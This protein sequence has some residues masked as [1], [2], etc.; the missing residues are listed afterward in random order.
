MP[1]AP[2]QR[3]LQPSRSDYRRYVDTLIAENDRKARDR[4]REAWIKRCVEGTW[5]REAEEAGLSVEDFL[6]PKKLNMRTS[7]S[8]G[9]VARAANSREIK[10]DLAA[11]G[12][13]TAPRHL[14]YD[15]TVR[16]GYDDVECRS[17]EFYGVDGK[18]VLV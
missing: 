16:S 12:L 15:R 11:I 10:A 2:V 4:Y 6:R 18:G 1:A 14:A 7:M 9:R 8:N 13:T 17:V 3:G 5:E